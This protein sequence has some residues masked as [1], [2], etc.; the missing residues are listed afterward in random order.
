MAKSE[1][2]IEHISR[3][4]AL[5]PQ[6]RE[7]LL[8]LE[9]DFRAGVTPK[10]VESTLRRMARTLLTEDPEAKR[11]YIEASIAESQAELAPV[12]GKQS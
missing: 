12:A 5:Y 9:V 10:Q 8:H 3:A 6:K 2:A 7:L 11:F 4:A 1:P